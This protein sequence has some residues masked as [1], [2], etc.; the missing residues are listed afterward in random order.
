MLQFDDK[1]RMEKV[2]KVIRHRQYF[3][4]LNYINQV[5]QV[6]KLAE[7]FVFDAQK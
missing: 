2:K 1:I 4:I 3:F 6:L 5:V 7:L